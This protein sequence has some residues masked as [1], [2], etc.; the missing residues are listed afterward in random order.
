MTPGSIAAN[1]F[2]L[3]ASPGD[4]VGA[5]PR[6]WLIAQFGRYRA[7][8][9]AIAAAPSTRAI[10]ARMVDFR[11]KLADLRRESRRNAGAPD[12]VPLG[13]L[14]QGI[15]GDYNDAYQDA[16]DAHVGARVDV[17]LGTDAPFVERL[18][19][20]WSNH[21]AMVGRKRELRALAG[22]F[23]VEAI[24]PHILGSFRDLL[25]AVEQHPAMLLNLDGAKSV[26]PDSPA[27]GGARR[28]AG[29][30]ENFA[31]EILELHTLG[32]RTGYTQADV[33]EFARALTGWT[34]P[35]VIRDT[36]DG[37]AGTFVFEAERHQPGARTIMGRSYAEGG[38][39]QAAAVLD[40]LAA[41]PATARHVATKLTRHFAGSPEPAAMVDR[42]TAAFMR[43]NGDL[44]TV[45]RALVDSPEAW[46]PQPVR[47][48]TPWDWSIAVLRA[49]GTRTV[50]GRSAIAMLAQLGQPVWTPRQ[51]SGWDDDDATWAAPDA[52]MRRI[53]ESERLAARMTDPVDA[54]ALATRLFPGA[55]SAQTAEGLARADSPAQALALLYCSPEMMRR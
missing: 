8:P 32:V 55:V 52:L 45:Y 13:T 14:R 12:A 49:T 10:S 35:R 46:V 19:Y 18:V 21:F 42:L 5:D 22:A 24:R 30:N 34:T 43:S 41:N 2:G 28:K 25:F 40:D 37:P 38:V 15:R 6:G 11:D 39:K 47:F 26:G 36:R 3:G 54:R 16:Y 29:L 50:D 44:P 48:R 1:R 4:D 20:F 51:V 53:E 9:P 7:G 27:A 23:E 33:T 31:R 17:A